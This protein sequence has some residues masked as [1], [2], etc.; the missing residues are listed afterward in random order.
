M[1]ND[2]DMDSFHFSYFFRCLVQNSL[3]RSLALFHYFCVW[4][5]YCCIYCFRLSGQSHLG[6]VCA[7]CMNSM[8]HIYILVDVLWMTL[9]KI[10]PPG[11]LIL[12]AIAKA[13]KPP[14]GYLILVAYTCL[15][16]QYALTIATMC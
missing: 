11:R 12:W 8:V 7:V 10:V 9:N 14:F 15:I 6:D 3:D 2:Y 13:L 4:L 16:L 1:N 5:L